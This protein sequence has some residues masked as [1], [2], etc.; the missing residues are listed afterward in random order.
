MILLPLP[1]QIEE[2]EGTLMLK[3]DTM[4]VMDG[5]CPQETRVYAGQL[6]EEISAW[7]GL[8]LE[9]GRGTFR[10]GDIA[11][12][13]NPAMKED[14]Y[15]LS[16]QEDGAYVTAGSPNALGW[17]VQTLRQIVR[18][19]AGLLPCLLIEDEPD[20]PNRGFY[21]D[22]TRGRIQTLDNLKALADTLCFYK[23]NQLQLYVEHTYLFRDLTELWRDDTPLTAEEIMELDQY[24]YERGIELVPSLATFGHLYKLLS[25]KTCEDLCELP[26]SFGK[27]FSFRD[28]MAHHTVN[29]SN[30]ASIA[31]VKDMIMEFMQLFRT[32]KFNLCADE[33][34]DLCKGKSADLTKE[35]E[36]G[37]I[38]LDYVKEL[39]DF[40]I[41]NGKVPMFW[42]DIICG[43]PELCEEIPSQVVCLTW[44]Y[45][46]NQSDWAAKI[47]YKAGALQYLCPG[48][49]GWNTWVNVIR[50]SY[51][52]VTRM[53]RFARQYDGIGVLNT[54]W[55][56]FGHINQPVFS[57]PGLIYGAV[58]SWGE[59][60]PEYEELNRQISILEFG[61]ASGELLNVLDKI[62]DQTVFEWYNVADIKEEAERG[63]DREKIHE[64]FKKTDMAKVPGCNARLDELEAALRKVSR[65]IDSSRRG[66]VE[67][68]HVAMEVARAWNNTGAF[69]AEVDAGNKPLNGAAVAE[70]LERS[71][72]HY[73]KLWRSNSKEGDLMKITEV[74]CWYAD[75]V[76]GFSMK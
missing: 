28:R 38:Y 72:H 5:S 60:V 17:G 42:G 14:H 29:V 69:L 57:I 48:A 32:D 49:R 70:A 6:K 31:L 12:K 36:T 51:L 74:F 3:A 18:Q 20:I 37:R 62:D 27:K 4:I 63:T 23:M 33:T 61:D 46:D 47:I 24:C 26:D 19:S 10:R 76:R 41:E 55:G 67:C 2:K 59:Q 35:K 13:I 71:L 39:F 30:P 8:C 9:M 1:K 16:I 15:S 75:L 66:I 7:A 25:T 53:C 21:H 73:Q 65:H 56:D 11:L 45:V 22:A 64:I 50:G 68:T 40:L 58:C 43:H 52:N 34:F 54:D 44:G